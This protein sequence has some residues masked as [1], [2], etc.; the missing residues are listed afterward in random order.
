MTVPLPHNLTALGNSTGIV[1][2]TLSVNEILMKD[3]FGVMLLV[4][5]FVITLL[6]FMVGTNNP[7]KAFVASAF[8]CFVMSML[9][10]VVGLVPDLAMYGSL[11]VAA[12]SVAFIKSRE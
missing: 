1:G 6:G 5:I 4:T 8:I 12:F 2:L 11:A 10:R 3:M 7:S 9:L